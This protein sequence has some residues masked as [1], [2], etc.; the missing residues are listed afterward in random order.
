M[1]DELH[2]A[3]YEAGL[4]H[5]VLPTDVGGHD[6]PLPDALRIFEAL[7]EVDASTAWC[8]AIGA[9]TASL[10]S[11]M[12]PDA[13]RE[14]MWSQPL[15]VVVGTFM[16][17]GKAVLEGNEYKVS[18]RW[19]FSSGSVGASWYLAYCGVYDGDEPR[20]DEMGNQ[21]V[22]ALPVP[23]TECRID[24]TWDSAGLRGTASHHVAIDSTNVPASY[25]FTLTAPSHPG[26]P[27]R[28]VPVLAV[29]DCYLA[30]IMTGVVRGA[31]SD[32]FR[33]FG[34]RAGEK[35][36]LESFPAPVALEV[37]ELLA[38][39][40]AWRAYV[41]AAVDTMWERVESARHDGAEA[42]EDGF[43]VR[44]ASKVAARRGPA[45]VSAVALL[46]G[47]RSLI[48]EPDLQ[49]RLRDA[50]AIASHVQYSTPI[51]T[52]LGLETVRRFAEPSAT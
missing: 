23:M 1:P 13:A 12:S 9:G 47:G 28:S 49:R 11:M 45:L 6:V 20:M 39:S 8:V 32:L 17:S 18:G 19:P 5:F 4:F 50:H 37:A 34:A 40:K 48:E 2:R 30:A 10:G 21:V 27:L 41:F 51:M 7:A 24:D 52:A 15:G 33:L 16:R 38:E 14:S 25:G 42:V 44:L 26:T 35:G 46:A 36:G 43:E 3:L 31:F 29:L 22:V